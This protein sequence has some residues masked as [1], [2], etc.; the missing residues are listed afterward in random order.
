MLSISTK[1]RYAL[2]LIV[3]L[4]LL[5]DINRPA[6]KRE[7]AGQEDMSEDYAEQLLIRMKSGGL[8][9]SRRGVQGGFVLARP[10]NQITAADVLETVEGPI[11]LAP[12]QA[13]SCKQ[14]TI[15]ITRDLW[16]EVQTAL[17]KILRNTTVA[18]LCERARKH[19]STPIS[20]SI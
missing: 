17:L 7:I 20:Y 14:A 11:Q 8:I 9:E 16:D 10:P 13:E 15:C 19:T 5:S 3:R 12:C 6:R 1:G 4:A 2:R 18:Q